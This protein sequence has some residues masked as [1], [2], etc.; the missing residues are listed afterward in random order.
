LAK[1]VKKSDLTSEVKVKKSDLTSEVKVKKSD[2]TSG[3]KVKKSYTHYSITFITEKIVPLP[4]FIPYGNNIDIACL[5]NYR[6]SFFIA[7]WAKTPEIWCALRFGCSPFRK[8]N[9]LG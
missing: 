2:L 7:D 8:L 4:V 3:V 9:I 1:V 6:T 5:G